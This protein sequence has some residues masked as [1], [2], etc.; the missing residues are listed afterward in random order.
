MPPGCANCSNAS[1]ATRLGPLADEFLQ[2]EPI[3]LER[4]FRDVGGA[5][6]WCN[7]VTIDRQPRPV[8]TSRGWHWTMR[9]NELEERYGRATLPAGAGGRRMRRGMITRSWATRA[10]FSWIVNIRQ[11]TSGGDFTLNRAATPGRC[12]DPLPQHPFRGL[13]GRLRFR[14]PRQLGLR[15]RDGPVGQ[16]AQSRHYDDLGELWRRGEY[17]PMSL[18]PNLARAG[19]IGV[20]V[21]TP[22]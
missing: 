6:A 7:V 22:R 15:H 19:N 20:T 21:L 5:A 14:R 10:L 18:D 2:V 3:F 11:P 17:I 8:P 9:C 16:S 13:P 12:P 1:S 4:V